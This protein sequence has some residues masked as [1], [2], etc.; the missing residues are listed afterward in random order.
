MQGLAGVLM[1]QGKFPDFEQVVSGLIAAQE[2]INGTEA[3]VTLM[4]RVRLAYA[5]YSQSKYAEAIATQEKALDIAR[6][7][8]GDDSRSLTADA[9][10]GLARYKLFAR[11]FAG[12]LAASEAGLALAPKR[13]SLLAKQAEALLFL[14]RIPEAEKIYGEHRGQIEQE[15][16]KRSWELLVTKNLDAIEKAGLTNPEFAK[17]RELLG[18]H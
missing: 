6:V 15:D 12:A 10:F 1:S 11:D 16:Q 13:L 5:Q 8:T 18:S 3:A 17:I 14:G 4:W 9:Y 7:G 2:C